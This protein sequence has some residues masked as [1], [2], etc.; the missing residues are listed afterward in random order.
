L[1]KE[2]ESTIDAIDTIKISDYLKRMRQS[3]GMTQQNVADKLG[4]TPQAVSKW[5][6]YESMP[7]ITLLPEIAGMYGV[8]VEDILTAGGVG[9]DIELSDVMQVLNTFVNDKV[10]GKVLEEF[11][12]AKSIRELRIP[13]DIFMALNNRQ[14]DTLLEILLHMEDYALVIDD[15]IQ[16]LNVAQ[17]ARLIMYVANEG[18]YDVLEML[19]PFMS[20]TTRTEVILLLLR[21]GK[22]DFLEE[23]LLY[24][25][26]GQKEM[27]IRYFLENEW[28]L[29]PLESFLPFFDKSNRKLMDEREVIQTIDQE[30]GEQNG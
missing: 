11:E 12:R 16:Y 19:I 8:T 10:F 13:I 17:R 6:R 3:N 25:N 30:R 1:R 20:R 9:Q 4:I 21:Q 23:M 14:K 15:M 29:E 24:L 22:F 26:H 27:I 5:E 2:G 7:D 28:D 18:D